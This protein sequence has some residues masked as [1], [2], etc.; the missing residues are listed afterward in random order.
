MQGKMRAWNVNRNDA[1][2]KDGSVNIQRRQ[3]ETDERVESDKFSSVA[4][5]K[6]VAEKNEE[7][8]KLKTR[9]RRKVP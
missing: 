7:G 9:G 4:E 8:K 3:R 5:L 2:P 6:S 1:K